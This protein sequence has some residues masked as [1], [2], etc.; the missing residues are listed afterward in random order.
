MPD[1][2]SDYGFC[3]NYAQI[4]RV[5]RHEFIS[6]DLRGITYKVTQNKYT[7]HAMRMHSLT[8]ASIIKQLD[9]HFAPQDTNIGRP[10][11]RW[12]WQRYVFGNGLLYAGKHKRKSP[13]LIIRNDL[14]G[15]NSNIV[16]HS[17]HRK[18]DG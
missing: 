3:G 10:L 16:F 7:P 6:S 17:H 18:M 14:I 5:S 2:S 9:V 8:V 13:I 1:G 15:W 11:L 12:K 4:M